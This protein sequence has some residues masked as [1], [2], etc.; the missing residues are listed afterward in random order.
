MGTSF[1][2]RRTTVEVINTGRFKPGEQHPGYHKFREEYVR[3]K[4][5]LT[6]LMNHSSSARIKKR[7]RVK[8][9]KYEAYGTKYRDTSGTNKYL[10][11]FDT[12]RDAKKAC[13]I[14]KHRLIK[15]LITF[16]ENYESNKPNTMNIDE[17]ISYK[18]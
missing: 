16:I 14:E 3:A 6:R 17:L 7:N 10:G 1:V 8:G 2:I 4:T 9:T 12:Y 15:A 18:L 11:L 5:I 13:Q